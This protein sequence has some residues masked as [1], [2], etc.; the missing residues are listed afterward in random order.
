MFNDA[1]AAESDGFFD[2]FQ[3]WI[4]DLSDDARSHPAKH[5]NA[6]CTAGVQ[7]QHWEYLSVEWGEHLN[8]KAYLFLTSVLWLDLREFLWY[9]VGFIDMFKGTVATRTVAYDGIW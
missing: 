5:A 2:G 3:T 6:M 7:L 9:Y 1:Q 4:S 8:E